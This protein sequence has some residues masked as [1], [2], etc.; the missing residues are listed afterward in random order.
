MSLISLFDLNT[1]LIPFLQLSHHIGGLFGKSCESAPIPFNLS[2]DD[3][4]M[5]PCDIVYHLHLEI[6]YI[7]YVY[8]FSPQ[9]LL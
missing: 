3:L 9:I 6:L 5:N 8:K 4:W 2:L 7:A 1:L